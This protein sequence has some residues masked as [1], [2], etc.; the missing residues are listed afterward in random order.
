M[1][2]L[3]CQWWIQCLSKGLGGCGGLFCLPYPK[4]GAPVAPCPTWAPTL[5]LPQL[6]FCQYK[7][8]SIFPQFPPSVPWEL[9]TTLGFRHAKTRVIVGPAEY[10]VWTWP[11]DI[12]VIILARWNK[13]RLG[14]NHITFISQQVYTV[15]EDSTILVRR[16]QLH[17][18]LVLKIL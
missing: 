7:C 10:A 6:T 12:T 18:Q 4:L 5:D 16:N 9:H 11:E 3:T 1:L 2:T 8:L 14:R 17:W 15:F 13:C